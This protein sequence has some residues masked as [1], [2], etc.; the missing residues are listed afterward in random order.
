MYIKAIILGLTLLIFSGCQEQK[1]EEKT[2][3][4]TVKIYDL[5]EN[6]SFQ[7]S[8]NYPAQ[9]EAFQDVTMAFE[10]QGKI[11]EMNIQEGQKVKK[12]T[13]IAKLDDTIYKANYSS[14]KANYEQAKKDFIRYEKLLKTKSVSQINF[15][16][17]KQNVEVT[18][19]AYEIAKKNLEESQLKAEFDGVIAKK[20]VNDYARVTAKQP[21]VRLQDNSSFKVKFFVAE[22]DI[23]EAKGDISAEHISKQ[24]DIFVILDNDKTK[25]FKA[26][27]LNISTA[28]D[29]VT[30][31]FETTLKLDAQ[32][33][34]TILP[35]MTAQVEI[36]EKNQKIQ[37]VF[38]PYK[39][40]FTNDTK[41]SFVWIVDSNSKVSKQEVELGALTKEYVEIKKGLNDNSKVVTSGVRFLKENDEIKEYKKL[42]K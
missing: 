31:T 29:E 21:I 3:I 9:I 34:I 22:S 30:R 13:I 27:F 39:A 40:V 26:S 38:I 33:N 18:K 11:I 5:N 32:K 23:K 36:I 20:I 2:I 19:S 14:A 35:G 10:V 7:R 15:D 12:G 6:K 42:D 8:N 1:I 28:A 4:R 41:K 37:R 17:Q 16:K 24:V 25:K